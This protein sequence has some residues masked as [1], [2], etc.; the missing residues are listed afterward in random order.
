MNIYDFGGNESEMTLE[1]WKS[2]NDSFC[3]IRG[4]CFC[5]LGDNMPVA[6]RWIKNTQSKGGAFRV[7]IY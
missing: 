5:N 1:Q 7:A 2:N 4:G 3:V 6:S